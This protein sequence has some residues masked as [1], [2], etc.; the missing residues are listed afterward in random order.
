MRE[1]IG[2][3][4][5]HTTFWLLMAAGCVAVA[6]VPETEDAREAREAQGKR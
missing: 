1:R 4:L 6:C 5:W 3:R 2:K